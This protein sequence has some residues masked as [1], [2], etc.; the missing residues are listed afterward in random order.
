MRKHCLTFDTSC[1]ISLLRLPG[2]STPEDEL[3]A[4]EKLMKLSLKR[5]IKISI[6]EKS[7]TEA[8]DNLSLAY[9]KD[10]QDSKRIEK[11]LKTL[12]VMDFFNPLRGRFIIGQSRLG[13]DTVLGSDEEALDYERIS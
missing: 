5:K 9:D 6:S 8:M 10:S 1:V 3:I 4:L 2:D 13:N 7:R 11:W 12:H